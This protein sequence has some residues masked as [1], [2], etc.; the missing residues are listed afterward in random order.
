M[1][2]FLQNPYI[3]SYNFIGTLG[4]Y[5]VYTLVRPINLWH[6][7]FIGEG[8]SRPRNA[9]DLARKICTVRTEPAKK[10]DANQR[11]AVGLG[12]ANYLVKPASAQNQN[13]LRNLFICFPVRSCSC[14]FLQKPW[15]ASNL[16][17]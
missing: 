17:Y 5:L 16:K 3:L 2:G 12:L 10:L 11:A 4:A 14:K 1:L 9:H 13:Y 15:Q 7:K 8:I 6:D